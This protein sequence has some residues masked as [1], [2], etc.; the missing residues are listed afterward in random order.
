[1]PDDV[2]ASLVVLTDGH[3]FIARCSVCQE[4]WEFYFLGRHDIP[5]FAKLSSADALV[6]VKAWDEAKPERDARA[7]QHAEEPRKRE[8]ESEV[9]IEREKQKEL[10]R[11]SL[12]ARA[13]PIISMLC[14]ALGS[15]IV[16]WMMI[17]RNDSSLTLLFIAGTA[18]FI[19]VVLA[20]WHNLRYS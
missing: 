6:R 7:V 4:Y 12:F 11:N 13:L 1:M 3:E 18:L 10:K 19:G 16:F 15:I 20:A 8:L 9:E 17:T 14:F 5:T 2:Q